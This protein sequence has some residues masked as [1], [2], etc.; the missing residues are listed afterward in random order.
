[1]RMSPALA[2]RVLNFLKR[3]TPRG[4]EESDDLFELI[5]FFEQALKDGRV[6]HSE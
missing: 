2:R 1:M 3:A 4:Q 6:K 5:Q